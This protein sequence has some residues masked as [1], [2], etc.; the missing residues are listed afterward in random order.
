MIIGPKKLCDLLDCSRKGSAVMEATS[1]L[2]DDGVRAAK[3]HGTPRL[4]TAPSARR[5]AL[6]TARRR[7]VP[8]ALNEVERQG[9]IGGAFASTSMLLRTAY[10]MPLDLAYSWR[11]YDLHRILRAWHAWKAQRTGPGYAK[12][13]LLATRR[14]QSGRGTQTEGPVKSAHFICTSSRIFS[15]YVVG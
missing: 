8:L 10:A 14:A 3:R 2:V 4:F 13:E 12:P 6:H 11:P 9:V 15:R 7:A 5:V 1:T